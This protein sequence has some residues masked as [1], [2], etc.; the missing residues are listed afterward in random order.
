MKSSKH[1]SKISMHH[2]KCKAKSLY[3]HVVS[4]ELPVVRTKLSPTMCKANIK[5]REKKSSANFA[6]NLE[7][8]CTW[9]EL[10]VQVSYNYKPTPVMEIPIT[11]SVILASF[12]SSLWIHV[13]QSELLNWN[14]IKWIILMHMDLIQSDSCECSLKSLASFS[15]PP[16]SEIETVN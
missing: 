10:P 3:T 16:V 8:C 11:K 6:S 5:W 9:L 13:S 1:A 15:K 7:I 4:L 14:Q 2:T 12:T